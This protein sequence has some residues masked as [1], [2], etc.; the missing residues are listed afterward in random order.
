MGTGVVSC[1][2]GKTWSTIALRSGESQENDGLR[3]SSR[4]P[5][6]SEHSPHKHGYREPLPFSLAL[7]ELL[8][9][10]GLITAVAQVLS[11]L[12]RQKARPQKYRMLAVLLPH[13]V[14][15]LVDV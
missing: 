6:Q 3:A 2:A 10:L 12:M 7:E 8:F 1:P 11:E 9:P 13:A 15:S 14:Y 4:R 5:P